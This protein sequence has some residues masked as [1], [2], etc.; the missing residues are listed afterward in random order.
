[1]DNEIS[2]TKVSL[3]V[4]Y[5]SAAARSFNIQDAINSLATFMQRTKEV[6]SAELSK[7][8]NSIMLAPKAALWMKLPPQVVLPEDALK[9]R[10][11]NSAN[12]NQVIQ[13]QNRNDG[14]Q[15]ASRNAWGLPEDEVPGTSGVKAKD[16]V[17]VR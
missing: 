5:E 15:Q 3:R 2:A 1:M 16:G 9:P 17:N 4:H 12:Q 14:F 11:A 7:K 6:E 10:N 13:D 8:F